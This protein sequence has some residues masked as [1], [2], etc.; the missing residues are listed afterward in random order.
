[1]TLEDE[2]VSQLLFFPV[3]HADEFK[4]GCIFENMTDEIVTIDDA[5]LQNLGRQLHAV[6]AY[7]FNSRTKYFGKENIAKI[8]AFVLFMP[9]TR[10]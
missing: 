1:M 4:A 10:R 7:Y 5:E 8:D 3:Y 9:M 6:H 2:G